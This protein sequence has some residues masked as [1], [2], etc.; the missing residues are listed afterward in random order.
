MI[1]SRLENFLIGQNAVFQHTVHKAAPTALTVARQDHVPAREM[2]KAVIVN[3]DGAYIMAVLPANR[4][5]DFAR[6]RTA[7]RANECRIASEWEM[8]QLFPDVELGAMP[9]L[10]VLYDLPVYVDET[11]AREPEIAFNAGTHTD[12]VHMSFSEFDR[13][14]SPTICTFAA[15]QV[16]ATPA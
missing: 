5:V 8:I 13:L 15:A 2:A 4:T 12:T 11:L 6:L 14:T 7:L 3:A 10:G 1:A 16:M 9:P